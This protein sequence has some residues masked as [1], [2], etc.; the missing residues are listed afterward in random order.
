MFDARV[1]AH[2][3]RLHEE[4]RRQWLV[5]LLHRLFAVKADLA[6]LVAYGEPSQLLRP[7]PEVDTPCHPML[8]FQRVG[9]LLLQPPRKARKEEQETMHFTSALLMVGSFIAGA[10]SESAANSSPPADPTCLPCKSFV[11]LTAGNPCNAF[12]VTIADQQAR[13][14]WDEAWLYCVSAGTCWGKYEILV[15]AQQGWSLEQGT[16]CDDAINDV[17]GW[18][19]G[20]VVASNNDP[21]GPP[22]GSGCG[23]ISP[24]VTFKLYDQPCGSNPRGTVQCSTFIQVGCTDCG[25]DDG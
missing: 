23:L 11:R 20:V 2:L 5:V 14:V 10:F 3:W 6:S 16:Y 4:G 7:P 9:I 8:Q 13:C 15:P 22:L 24:P 21:A 19:T 17:L 12:F 18:N 25:Q 1:S